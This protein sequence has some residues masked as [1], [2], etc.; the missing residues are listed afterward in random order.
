MLGVEMASTGEVGCLG[1]DLQEALLA[2]LTAAGFRIPRRGV[3][4]S[5]GPIVSPPTP[6]KR[7]EALYTEDERAIIDFD[8]LWTAWDMSVFQYM[9]PDVDNLMGI[10]QE[11]WTNAA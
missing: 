9:M 7:V 3:L 6:N 11:E 10:Q 5:L 1:D 2:A 8:Y 4:L